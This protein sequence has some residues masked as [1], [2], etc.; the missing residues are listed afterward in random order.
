MNL[1]QS[2]CKER[3]GKGFIKTYREMV[4]EEFYQEISAYLKNLEIVQ[5]YRD[6]IL[7]RPVMARVVGKY[8]VDFE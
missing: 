5:E 4:T 3:F 2:Q 7:I 6:D 8:P 1:D